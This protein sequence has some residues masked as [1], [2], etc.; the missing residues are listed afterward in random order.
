[1]LNKTQKLYFV[2]CIV[3]FATTGLYGVEL[4]DNPQNDQSPT[5]SQSFDAPLQVAEIALLPTVEPFSATQNEPRKPS[6]PTRTASRNMNWSAKSIA[7]SDYFLEAEFVNWQIRRSDLD[8]A[9]S[10]NLNLGGGLD[11]AVRHEVQHQSEPGFRMLF[12]KQIDDNWNIAYGLTSY[13]ASQNASVIA[14]SG[15]V[16][17]TLTNPYQFDT[18]IG[19]ANAQSSFNQNVFDIHLNRKIMVGGKPKLKIYGSLRFADHENSKQVNYFDIDEITPVGSITTDTTSTG[20]GVRIGG[21]GVWSLSDTVFAFA[22]G[23]TSLL[24]NRV[25]VTTVHTRIPGAGP[26]VVNSVVDSYTQPLSVLGASVGVGRRSGNFEIRLG[27][28]MS[29]WFNLG[30]KTAITNDVSASYYAYDRNESDILL[31]GLFLRCT[32]D[33]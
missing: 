8:Y 30:V 33:F 27:Y 4:P 7:N 19:R 20:F 14:G 15:L 18:Q 21:E 5:P 16:Y 22:N 1:M 24:L 29:T 25:E 32:W 3:T 6:Y 28:E 9:I 31:E 13:G 17:A 26:D 10:G 12:G 23:E 11:N 2:I